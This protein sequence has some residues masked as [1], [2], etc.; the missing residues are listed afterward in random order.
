MYHPTGDGMLN[1]LI[2]PGGTRPLRFINDP[3]RSSGSVIVTGILARPARRTT[4]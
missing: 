2:G 3:T 4:G 1:S